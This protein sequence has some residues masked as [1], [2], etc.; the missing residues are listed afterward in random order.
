MAG[1]VTLNRLVLIAAGTALLALAGQTYRRRDKPITES[2]AVLLGLLGI[3]A[4][5]TG[6]TATTGWPNKVIWLHT[7]L[8]I[9]VALLYFSFDYYGLVQFATRERLGA[10]AVPVVVGSLGGTTLI[11]GTTESFAWETPVVDAL[12]SLPASVYGVATTFDQIGYYYTIFLICIA[13][14]LVFRNVTRYQH[15][16]TRLGVVIAFIGIWPWFGNLV[17]PELGQAYGQLA[18]LVALSTGYS[19][20][21][22]VAVVVVGPLAL[23]RSTPA[24]GN[25][26]PNRVLDS[27]DDPVVMIDDHEQILRLNRAATET[28]DSTERDVVGRTLTDV[29]DTDRSA[30]TDGEIVSLDTGAGVRQFEITRSAVED[31]WGDERGEVFVFADVTG[32]L[33][34]EQ[35]LEVLNRVLRHNL[36]NSASSIIARA[37]LLREGDEMA[38][39]DQIVEQTQS[40][41]GTAERAREIETMMTATTS[42]ASTDLGLAVESVVDRVGDEYPHVELTTALP[43]DARAAVS[44]R[45]LDTVLGNVVENAAEHNDA[46]QPLVVVSAD[47]TDDGQLTIAVADNGPGIPEHEQAVLDAGEEDQLDHGSGL[48]LW[49]AHWGVTQM[50]GDLSI[51]ENDPRGAVVSITVPMPADRADQPATVSEPA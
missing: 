5:C 6:V 43:D 27:M 21:A 7:N 39:P 14:V 10:L 20:S 37:E 51:S 38:D 28:F 50:G 41:I 12:A 22:V 11:L 9:P 48:G 23:F 40:L 2:F 32:R 46:D 25:I 42:D 19:V 17:V 44:P 16:D 33:T 34:R 13:L 29:L 8:A 1:L 18:G 4:F 45:V 35:R 47:R 36:R 30:L 24:A 15:L 3:T 31:R 26:G 49:A